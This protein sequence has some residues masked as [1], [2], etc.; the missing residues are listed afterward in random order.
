MILRSLFLKTSIPETT[1]NTVYL[2]KS[3]FAF[4]TAS[5][6]FIFLSTTWLSQGQLW[7]TVEETASPI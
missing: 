6:C 7:T 1:E 3:Y 4:N 2:E 5:Y